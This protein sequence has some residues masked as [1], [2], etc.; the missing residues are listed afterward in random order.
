MKLYIQEYSNR[1]F[2]LPG[3][4]VDGGESLKAAALRE[5][6][7]EAGMEVDLKGLLAVEYNPCGIDGESFVVRMRVIYYAEPTVPFL[8]RPPKCR[9]DFES[10]GA[11]WC[12]AAEICGDT[13]RL[14]G[15]EPRH[16]VKHLE[17]G[18]L[19]HPLSVLVE[20]DC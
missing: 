14:R 6:L 5:T 20:R 1:G 10:V 16:W 2:W 7:E 8:Q 15:G 18:G 11:S 3:G 17:A 19:I 12:T 4:K 13:L 9:P